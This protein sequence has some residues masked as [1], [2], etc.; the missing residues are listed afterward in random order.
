MEV[1]SSQAVFRVLSK[2]FLVWTPRQLMP[3]SD[4]RN[5]ARH[6]QSDTNHHAKREARSGNDLALR[7]TEG[8]RAHDVAG[9]A[10][11]MLSTS[12][13]FEPNALYVGDK[14]YKLDGS[15]LAQRL[16]RV[17]FSIPDEVIEKDQAGPYL[18]D[19]ESLRMPEYDGDNASR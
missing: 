2:F 8:E 10:I 7:A 14:A 19:F 16:K 3:R 13:N 18:V 11:E 5:R 17:V 1:G 15:E 12:K 6:F 4:W 9:A